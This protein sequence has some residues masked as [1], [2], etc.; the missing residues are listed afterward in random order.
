M[1]PEDEQEQVQAVFGDTPDEERAK[2]LSDF[3]DGTVR[4]IINCMVLTEGTDLPVC[5]AV[6]NLRPT[7]RNTLYQQMVGRGTRLYPT[8][9]YCLVLDIIP[10][11]GS[12]YGRSLCTAPTLFGIDP[13]ALPPSKRAELTDDVDLL[14]F[15][16]ALSSM[17]AERSAR[18]ELLICSFLTVRR[19]L[20]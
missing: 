6:M 5:D 10:D 17:Y 15:C 18:V 12:S 4:C 3:Q 16:D 14:E 9:E 2:I 7:C 20:V 13:S 19:S 1:L 8:K 11:T